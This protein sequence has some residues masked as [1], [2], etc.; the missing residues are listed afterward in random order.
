MAP[1][2]EDEAPQQAGKKPSRHEARKQALD[3]LYEADLKDKPLAGVLAAHLRD[4]GPM[5]DYSVALVRGVSRNLDQID[6]LIEEYSREWKLARMPIVDRNI[7]RLGLFELRFS[8]EI[9]RA[10]A[11]DEAVELAK[12]LSTADSGRFVNGLLSRA[13]D[14][15]GTIAQGSD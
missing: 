15:K 2:T 11:I 10:V 13:S 3:V 6:A 1:D 12:E 7:L 5:D 8:D 14:P 9:P 4:E